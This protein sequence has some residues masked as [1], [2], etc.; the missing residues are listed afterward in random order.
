[1]YLKS[2]QSRGE[3]E[4]GVWTWPFLEARQP[5]KQTRYCHVKLP[6]VFHCGDFPSESESDGAMSAQVKLS[7]DLLEKALWGTLSKT[8]WHCSTRNKLGER[9]TFG[10]NSL[11]NK[12]TEHSF[13]REFRL[14]TS[15][16]HPLAKKCGCD[17]TSDLSYHHCRSWLCRSMYRVGYLNEPLPKYVL[18]VAKLAC[19]AQLLWCKISNLHTKL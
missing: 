2:V 19:L 15:R 1:M 6:Y 12:N 14:A 4:V 7:W 5:W 16:N 8:S 9:I 17:H 3:V 10:P 11:R 13:L 18:L